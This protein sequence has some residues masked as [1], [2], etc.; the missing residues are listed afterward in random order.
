MLFYQVRRAIS[1]I[2]IAANFEP[3]GPVNDGDNACVKN[4]AG[5]DDEEPLGRT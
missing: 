2:S 3:V 4:D 5:V 1:L